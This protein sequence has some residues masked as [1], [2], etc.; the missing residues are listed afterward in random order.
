MRDLNEVNVSYV[1][2]FFLQVFSEWLAKEYRDKA[3]L[4][5]EPFV[6][7]EMVKN[8]RLKI[9]PSVDGKFSES[10][11]V[12]CITF[13]SHHSL[14]CGPAVHLMSQWKTSPRNCLI[15][16]DPEFPEDELL[17]PYRPLAMKVVYYPMVLNILKL[18]E[19]K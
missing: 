3:Y 10:Y 4:P 8:S 5:E 16:T 1:C 14:R 13:C 18:T 11:V 9:F 19:G 6:H 7:G 15:L 17:A 2:L 12:P